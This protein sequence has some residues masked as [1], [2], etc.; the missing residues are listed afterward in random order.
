MVSGVSDFFVYQRVSQ[1]V[2]LALFTI[3]FAYAIGIVL[4]ISL[5]AATSGG[6]FSPSVTITLSLFR[7]FPKRKAVRFV[8]KHVE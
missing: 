7:G 8:I 2:I 4:A 5:C 1:L 3:G 6:H